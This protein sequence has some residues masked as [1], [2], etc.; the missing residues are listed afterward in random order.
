MRT[1]YCLLL[2]NEVLM[3]V[4]SPY[5]IR[6]DNWRGLQDQNARPRGQDSQV[7]DLGYGR[8][9]TLQN[10]HIELLQRCTRYHRCV[11][12]DRSGA[13]S[14][15]L[16]Q[17]ARAQR[18]GLTH[19]LLALAGHIRERQDLVSLFVNA[20]MSH[21]DPFLLQAG[22]NRALCCRRRQSLAGRQQV[23]PRR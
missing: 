10:H 18:I 14:R 12:C 4:R 6:I 19:C 8:S 15:A 11:R 7:A 23:R 5:S 13:L 17:A 20:S 21:T 9:R 2:V 16:L 3:L 1:T 22:R